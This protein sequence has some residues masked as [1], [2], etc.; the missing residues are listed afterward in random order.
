MTTRRS[1]SADAVEIPVDII[2]QDSFYL[3]VTASSEL[4]ISSA[5]RVSRSA[6]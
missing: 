2:K 5:R 6:K 3:S 1:I 4:L